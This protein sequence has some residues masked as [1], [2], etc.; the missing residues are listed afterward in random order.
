MTRTAS[1]HGEQQPAF[2]PRRQPGDDRR[3]EAQDDRAIGD[4]QT[5]VADA[6]AKPVG[7]HRQH[8]GRRQNGNA[9]G[10]IAEHQGNAGDRSRPTGEL[11]QQ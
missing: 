3:A 11:G 10:E 1:V 7:Q 9:G 4:Q 2:D 8:S 6:D 5:G